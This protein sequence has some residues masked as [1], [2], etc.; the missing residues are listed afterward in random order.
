MPE[1]TFTPQ[2]DISEMEASGVPEP[3]ADPFDL[4]YSQAPP[5]FVPIVGF[6][7]LM[8]TPSPPVVGNITGVPACLSGDAR[9]RLQ[10]GRVIDIEELRVGDV[11]EAAKDLYSRVLMFTHRD[12]YVRSRMVVLSVEDGEVAL[13]PGHYVVTSGGLIA[14][15]ELR[16]GDTLVDGETVTGVRWATKTG[17]YNPQTLVGTIRP[18]NAPTV[19]SYTTA[20]SVAAGH[21]AM[22]P[23]RALARSTGA[24]LGWVSAVCTG[25]GVV[26]GRMLDGERVLQMVRQRV[27]MGSIPLA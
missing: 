2:P 12:R 25:E 22:A 17:L 13:S 16:V 3:T 8:E 20:L 27:R 24:T 6:P 14:A 26:C 19:S 9:L 15:S 10:G 23:L 21:A 5:S 1:V 4:S 11:V 18:V 7:G